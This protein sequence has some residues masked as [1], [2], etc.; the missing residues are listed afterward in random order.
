MA[1]AHHDA[2]YSSDGRHHHENR[3]AANSVVNS[4]GQTHEVPNL[5]VA[6]P[7]IFP[8]CGASNPTYAVFALS[9]PAENLVSNWGS[10]RVRQFAASLPR[11]LRAAIRGQMAPE[12]H[13]SRPYDLARH[14]NF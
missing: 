7:G 13:P 11:E 4:F 2:G 1:G 12:I 3:R 5:C 10:V 9:L 6:G 8:T 14:K